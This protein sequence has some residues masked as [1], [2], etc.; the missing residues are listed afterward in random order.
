[1]LAFDWRVSCEAEYDW[2]VLIVDGVIQ[3]ALTGETGWQRAQ[4]ALGEGDHELRWEYWKDES[5]AV[6]LDA[7]WLDRVSWSGAVPPQAGFTLWLADKG[8]SGDA[9]GLFGLDRN[10]DG[11]PNGFEYA[12]GTNLPPGVL[13]LDLRRVNGRT[14]VET[15][16]QDAS[17][18]PY[19]DVRV[20]GSTNLTDWSLP[21][22]PSVDT[23]GKPA[24]RAWYEAAGTPPNRAFFK[25]KA[26]L[27]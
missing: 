9:A 25:L 18:A 23:A 20:L 13:L 7:G 22:V 19:V 3:L 15:P 10:G 1:M 12:F 14:V 4:L 24:N 21:V 2:L 11:L 5:T 8:L 16:A 17:T 26:E 6:G 27:K